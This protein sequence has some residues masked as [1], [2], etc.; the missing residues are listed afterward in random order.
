[1]NFDRLLILV[2]LVVALVAV[3]FSKSKGFIKVAEGI[4]IA[5]TVVVLMYFIWVLISLRNGMGP[6]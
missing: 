4:I 1:M 6:A 2:P 3:N 5:I